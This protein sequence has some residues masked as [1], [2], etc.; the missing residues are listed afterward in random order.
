MSIKVY[1]A[2]R[3]AGRP[4]DLIPMLSNWK[5]RLYKRL[6]YC[7]L[8]MFTKEKFSEGW[9]KYSDSVREHVT[10]P[11]RNPFDYEIGF[12]MFQTGRHIILAPHYER[13]NVAASTS[14]AFIKDEPILEEFGYWNNTDKPDNVSE[15]EWKKRAKIY[16]KINKPVYV[17]LMNY[18]SLYMTIPILGDTGEPVKEFDKLMKAKT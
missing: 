2:Y 18:D 9:N 14:F 1:E 11:G 16:D 5:D 6:T 7:H 8:K 13:M 4:S 10:K 17:S 12:R 3:F 15:K